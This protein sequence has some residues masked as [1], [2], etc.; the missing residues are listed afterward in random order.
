MLRMVWMSNVEN[1]VDNRDK[2]VGGESKTATNMGRVPSRYVSYCNKG[3]LKRY[4]YFFA[5]VSIASFA[6]NN[7]IRYVLKYP[8]CT[9]YLLAKRVPF[10]A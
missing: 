7:I 10:L 1:G 6:N 9:R 3:K 2:N 4:F 5:R 8:H